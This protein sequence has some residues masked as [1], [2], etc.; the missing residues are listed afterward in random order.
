MQYMFVLKIVDKSRSGK[1]LYAFTKLLLDIPEW[2][3]S[4]LKGYFACFVNNLKTLLKEMEFE[5][6][7]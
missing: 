2:T 1:F 3:T 4:P 5:I 7:I 6:K